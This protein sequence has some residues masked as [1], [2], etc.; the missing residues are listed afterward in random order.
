MKFGEG[1]LYS[2]KKDQIE[3]SL[4]L[5]ATNPKF[6]PGAVIDSG[7]L[8]LYLSEYSNNKGEEPYASKSQSKE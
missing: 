2:I 5:R 6:D 3:L 8:H 4:L 7:L 1:I